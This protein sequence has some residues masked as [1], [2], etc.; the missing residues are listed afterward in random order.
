M[1]QATRSEWLA[2]NFSVRL[3]RLSPKRKSLSIVFRPRLGD[4]ALCSSVQY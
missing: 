4:A 2:I 1:P 3:Y